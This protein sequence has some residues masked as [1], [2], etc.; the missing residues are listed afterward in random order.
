MGSPEKLTMCFIYSLRGLGND[1]NEF[2]IRKDANE[3]FNR[4]LM[5]LNESLGT[6]F[7]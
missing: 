1:R 2:T 6:C 5:L 7:R 3:H 4:T